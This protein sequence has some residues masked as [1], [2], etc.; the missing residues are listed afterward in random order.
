MAKQDL[1]ENIF[2]KQYSITQYTG[3]CKQ[4]L[5]FY[6][7]P[8]STDSTR[9]IAYEFKDLL[10]TGKDPESIV[11][12]N[13]KIYQEAKEMVVRNNPNIQISEKED[14]MLNYYLNNYLED[15][16]LLITSLEKIHDSS[17]TINEVKLFEDELLTLSGK[18]SSQ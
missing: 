2:S 8:S 5:Q 18:L 9:A 14:I 6:L 4:R 10:V 12:R 3:I 17:A 11:A 7:S 15:L 1:F 16:H 13:K